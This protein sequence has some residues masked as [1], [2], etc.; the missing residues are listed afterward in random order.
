MVQRP[1]VLNKPYF[2][3]FERTLMVNMAEYDNARSVSLLHSAPQKSFPLL[4]PRDDI[5]PPKVGQW[6]DYIYFQ[7]ELFVGRWLDMNKLLV[8]EPSVTVG[9]DMQRLIPMA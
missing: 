6:S 4:I 5:S 2:E 9:R 7:G 8:S 1:A 3:L